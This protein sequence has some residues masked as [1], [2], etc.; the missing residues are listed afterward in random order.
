MEKFELPLS[1]YTIGK[2]LW[3]E[4]SFLLLL[5]AIFLFF[6]GLNVVYFTATIIMYVLLLSLKRNRIIVQVDFNSEEREVYLH[7]FYL[8]FFKRREIIP[9]QNLNYKMSL[10]RFGF[11][12]ATPTLELFKE[13]ILVGE[14]R[15]EG[16]W[17]WQE[18]TIEQINQKL[19]TICE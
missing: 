6:V 11:G 16:K 17:K 9:Y 7:Y 8:I 3:Q 15:K 1:E 18:E 4:L 13:K 2:R 14:I 19:K 12:A 10:K 5:L